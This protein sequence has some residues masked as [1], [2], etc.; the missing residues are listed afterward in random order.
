MSG[1]R[2]AVEMALDE[3]PGLDDLEAEEQL[4]LI[5]LPETRAVV[6]LR[7]ERELRDG[8]KGRPPGSRN[9]RTLEMANYLL[10]RYS[11][12]LEVLAQIATARVDDLAASLGCKKLEALQ[13][14]RLAAIALVPFLHQKMPV[15]VDITNR[16]VVHLDVTIDGDAAL[17]ADESEITLTA[18]VVENIM[19]DESGDA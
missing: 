5:G 1:E 12:P 18:R 2:T 17:P 14:K 11:S 4:D 3:A 6:N 8:R 15:A 7:E 9:K 16:K 10:S 19:R 13:E